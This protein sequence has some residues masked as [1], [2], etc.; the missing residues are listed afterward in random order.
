MRGSASVKAFEVAVRES[1]D[2]SKRAA[3]AKF[4]L[5]SLEIVLLQPGNLHERAK[6]SL[7]QRLTSV[8]GDDDPFT[9]AR[10]SENVMATVN[11]SQY[12]T[13]PLD[14]L[15]KLATGDLLHTVTSSTRSA[16]PAWAA[17]SSASSQP[18]IASRTFVR[19]SSI[20]SPCETHPGN[21]GTSAQ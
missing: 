6:Q 12:P 1:G 18:S 4:A 3:R 20:V 11:P 17:P 8:D 13:A 7:F 10:H 16:A 9:S 15:R 2:T 5:A 19:T 21:A 14:N